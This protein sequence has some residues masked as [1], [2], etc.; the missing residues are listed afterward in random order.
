MRLSISSFLNASIILGVSAQSVEGCIC[1]VNRV[2]YP[3][4]FSITSIWRECDPLLCSFSYDHSGAI[5]RR[6]TV[7]HFNGGGG[8]GQLNV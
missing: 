6:L 8:G 5:P 3:A 4:D 2:L 7:S 1:Q